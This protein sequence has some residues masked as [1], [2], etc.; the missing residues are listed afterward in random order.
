MARTS[1]SRTTYDA[2]A[3]SFS[4]A[5]SPVCRSHTHRS[6][7]AYISRPVHMSIS[8]FTTSSACARV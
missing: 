5:V 7:V 1:P 2:H 8:A 3:P 4:N 6:I